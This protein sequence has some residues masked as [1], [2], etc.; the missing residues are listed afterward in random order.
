MIYSLRHPKRAIPKTIDELWKGWG[1]AKEAL[2]EGLAR[3][4]A[5]TI[6]V[7]K[8]N[9]NKAQ[10]LS[11]S[12]SGIEPYRKDFETDECG[13]PIKRELNPKLEPVYKQLTVDPLGKIASISADFETRETIATIARRSA[14]NVGVPPRKLK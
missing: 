9:G 10:L 2:L 7:I 12:T 14:L 8:P 5:G 4:K 13:Y 11:N 3:A 6:T 1:A